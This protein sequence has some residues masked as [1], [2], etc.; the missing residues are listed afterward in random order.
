MTLKDSMRKPNSLHFYVQFDDEPF[1][2]PGLPNPITMIRSALPD[3]VRT[4]NGY[5]QLMEQFREAELKSYGVLVNNFYELESDYCEQYK[6]IMGHKVF[7]VGPAA[8]IH[9]NAAEQLWISHWFGLVM[10]KRGCCCCSVHAVGLMEGYVDW[11][12]LLGGVQGSRGSAV[13]GYCFAVS[14]MLV[15]FFD[16]LD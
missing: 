2:I 4:P 7:H 3:Y 8:L 10:V 6:K 13:D 14:W 11:K 15:V 12:S 16:S 9:R 1:L 5:T